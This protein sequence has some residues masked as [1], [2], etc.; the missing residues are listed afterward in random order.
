MAKILVID[1]E[2]GIR[3]LLGTLS[4]KRGRGVVTRWSR[5]LEIFR[6]ER[7]DIIWI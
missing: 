4:A 3:N 5:G 7:P 6:R 1:D 2:E